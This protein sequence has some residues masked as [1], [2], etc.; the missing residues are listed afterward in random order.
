VCAVADIYRGT[1]IRT[2]PGSDAYACHK[3]VACCKCCAPQ[4]V[5]LQWIIIA[6]TLQVVGVWIAMIEMSNECDELG[7]F[8]CLH[9]NSSS[10]PAN[11]ANN[12]WE[13]IRDVDFDGFWDN[14]P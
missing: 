13:R 11:V 4:C 3:E 10:M 8:Q 6:F 12:W 14:G 2:V 5:G 9:M 7:W 1:V